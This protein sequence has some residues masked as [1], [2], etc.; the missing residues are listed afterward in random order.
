MSEMVKLSLL[1]SAM[2]VV[3]IIGAVYVFGVIRDVRHREADL[4]QIVLGILIVLALVWMN[5]WW[6]RR[7]G[8]RI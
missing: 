1:R 3:T 4:L 6:F 5:R 2:I 8:S 7:T